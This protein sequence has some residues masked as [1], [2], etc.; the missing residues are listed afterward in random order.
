MKISGFKMLAIAVTDV[1]KA[2]EFYT[3]TLGLKLT[4]DA[5]HNGQRWVSLELADGIA[6]TLSNVHESMKP[7]ALKFYLGTSDVDSTQK[8]LSDK[9]VTPVKEGDDWGKWGQEGEGQHWFEITDP[10]GN[11]ILI[12]PSAYEHKG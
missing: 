11:H 10:D 3:E 8:E 9:G 6:I 2:K 12:I 1:D 4:G 5:G 7:G